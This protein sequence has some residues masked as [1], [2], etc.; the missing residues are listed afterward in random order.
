MVVFYHNSNIFIVLPAGRSRFAHTRVVIF[1]R[2]GD[3]ANTGFNPVIKSA[4]TPEADDSRKSRSMHLRFDE[5]AFA[6]RRECSSDP[7]F[8]RGG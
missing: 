1:Q 7:H 4:S 2:F 6:A 3:P 8:K 5:M